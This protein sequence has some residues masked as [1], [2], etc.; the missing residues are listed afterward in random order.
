MPDGPPSDIAFPESDTY[1]APG[2]RVLAGAP[3]RTFWRKLAA[4]AGPAYLVSVGYMD[5]GNWATD[6]AGGA[7]FG[8]RLLW[9]LVMS[10][11]MAILLQ[12]F[13]ARLGIVT[14]MDLA[15]ACRA[16]FSRRVS[17]ALVDP[18][19]DRHRRLRPR[20]GAGSAIGLQPPLRHAAPLAVF[21]TCLD[22]FIFAPAPRGVRRMEAFILAL[23]LTDR[24]LPQHRGLPL[25]AQPWASMATGL[26]PALAAHRACSTSPSASS[27]PR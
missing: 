26:V 12:S 10:N 9:V 1:A 14:G 16:M 27:A 11:L 22:T 19:R 25:P 2:P 6:I 17:W 20:R 23:I 13:S 8:Y 24:H 18:C 7:R 15:Q 3:P 4:A 5:P 21:V